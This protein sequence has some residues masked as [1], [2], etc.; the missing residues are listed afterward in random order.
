MLE[1]CGEIE[2]CERWRRLVCGSLAKILGE[3]CGVFEKIAEFLAGVW[4]ARMSKANLVFTSLGSWVAQSKFSLGGFSVGG[5]WCECGLI[6]A[7]G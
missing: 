1:K 3:F 2:L 6:G 4:K 7:K 5:G